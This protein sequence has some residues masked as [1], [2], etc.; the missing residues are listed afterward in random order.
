MSASQEKKRRAEERSAGTDKKMIAREEAAKKEKRNKIVWT[1]VG[2]V[3]AVALVFTIVWNSSLFYNDFSA[4]QVGDVKYTASEV[5]F[6]YNSSY[7]SFITNYSSYLQAMGLDTT[8]S[9]SSQS[10]GED[11]TWADFF[12]DQAVSSLTN[13]TILWQE[14]QNEGFSLSEAD[15]QSLDTEL[16]SISEAATG[17]NFTSVDQF[18]SANYGKGLT[19][20]KVKTLMER[21]YIAQAYY[22]EKQASFSYTEDEL[23][24]Y[25]NK[26]AD[27]YDNY[28]Y[29]YYYID[30]SEDSDNGIDSETAM[31][32]AEEKAKNILDGKIA[33]VDEFK[34]KV[35]A[36][37]N[38]DATETVTA[39]SSLGSDFADWMKDASRS[40]GD[41]EM[42]KS[43]SGYYVIYFEERDNNDYNTVNV[44]HILIK[45]V[46]DENG[47][48]T[49]EA[50]QTAK[51]KAEE[52]LAE[53]EDGAATED[54][55]AELAN[56]SSEDTGS[57]TKGGLYE[58]VRKNQMVATF[59]DW[60]FDETRK[61]GD[62]GIVFNEDSNYCGYHVMYF[63][64]YG[65]NYRTVLADSSLRS[66]DYNAWYEEVSA[67]YT[68]TKGFT[69][70]FVK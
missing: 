27:N 50:K 47:K 37:T 54:S 24:D 51:D 10:Y 31:A 35:L 22:T 11:Q 57:N 2:I 3:L 39:G 9:L 65:D 68:T 30:G 14:A 42:F 55:F 52:L 33:Y 25:Y 40:E 53:W 44:R 18:L 61:A 19:Y 1:I 63:V 12:R 64:G 20:D 66:E 70:K 48:Y 16:A 7:Y 6:Y 28:K 5:E 59:S 36:L 62:T 69:L 49:D 38:G 45:A 15:Q 32:N 17:S 60:C 8:K 41:V 58:D 13:I 56:S 21:S 26:D 29:V 23:L 43:T 4:V 67:N 46:A 34:A